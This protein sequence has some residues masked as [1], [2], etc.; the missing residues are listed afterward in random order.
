MLTA[1]IFDAGTDKERVLLR[2]QVI[3]DDVL[4]Y[5]SAWCYQRPDGNW[6]IGEYEEPR[7]EAMRRSLT[8]ARVTGF[9]VQPSDRQR[10]STR[11]KRWV[12]MPR[13]W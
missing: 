12:T 3:F 9:P 5:V 13:K 4:W 10:L 2:G 1:K 7:W 11:S 6:R 8:M